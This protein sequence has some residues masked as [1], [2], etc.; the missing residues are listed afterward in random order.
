M[1]NCYTTTNQ[2]LMCER[3]RTG[4]QLWVDTHFDMINSITKYCELLGRAVF[5][6]LW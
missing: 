2:I 6:Y 3:H 1:I 5:D 4:F